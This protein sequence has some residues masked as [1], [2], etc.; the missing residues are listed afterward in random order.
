MCDGFSEIAMVVGA[1]SAV[2]GSAYSY[3]QGQNAASASRNA[4]AQ[5][6]QSQNAAT[7]ARVAAQQQQTQEEAAAANRASTSFQQSA[8]AQQSAQM[9]AMQAKQ[10]VLKQANEQQDAIGH[11]RDQT[12][13]TALDTVSPDQLAA[14]QQQAQANQQ[15]MN[16]PVVQQAATDPLATSPSSSSV[17]QDASARGAEAAG[18]YVQGYG[19]RLARLN[20]YQAPLQTLHDTTTGLGTNLMPSAVADQIVR[21]QTPALLLPGNTAYTQAG[22]YGDTARQV[23]GI[24]Q[25][26]EKGLA[27]ARA[28]ASIGIQNIKQADD[29]AMI[30]GNLNLAQADYAS[31]AALG[32][33]AAQLGN[34]ALMYG[35]M[36]GGVP[37]F[38]TSLAK[39]YGGA[40]P[41][42]APVAKIG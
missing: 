26:G 40:A 27:D 23:I 41:A 36:T 9:Q 42:A 13:Q 20:S 30:Q 5:A 1:V 16:A 3:V 4:Q 11:G 25:G 12:V 7:M 24:T 39:L 8:A 37:A 18:K 28:A 34:Q 29:A 22:Q 2:A 38:K 21:S 14:A 31:R 15:A 6:A 32:Q 19:D 33:G 17:T 10:D 35:A